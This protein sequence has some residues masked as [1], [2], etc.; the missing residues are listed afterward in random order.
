MH[1]VIA[2]GV[3][4]EWSPPLDA[5][6]NIEEEARETMDRSEG[7]GLRTLSH[8]SRIRQCQAATLQRPD[9]SGRKPGQG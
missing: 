6:R 2:E 1:R 5:E 3:G 9:S 8:K 4:A 7:S